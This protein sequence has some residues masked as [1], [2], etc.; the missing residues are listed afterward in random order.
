MDN[1]WRNLRGILESVCYTTY[2][3]EGYM[4]IESGVAKK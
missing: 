3:H 4:H 1:A 2:G